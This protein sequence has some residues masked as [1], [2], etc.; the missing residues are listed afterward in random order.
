[1]REGGGE[2]SKIP[3]KGVEQNRGEGTQRFLK[4]GQS[5]SRDGFLKKGGWNPLQAMEK[6]KKNTSNSISVY[7]R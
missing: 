2:L 3:D 1:M 4:G 7:L 6:N 5:G